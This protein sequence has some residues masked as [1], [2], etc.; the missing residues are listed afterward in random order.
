MAQGRP[1]LRSVHRESPGRVIEPRKQSR[2]EADTVVKVEG[3]RVR[4]VSPEASHSAG[5]KSRAWST[6]GFPRNLGGLWFSV[7]NQ[8]VRAP[9][10][11]WSRLA[12]QV[13]C[14]TERKQHQHNGTLSCKGHGR[15]QRSRSFLIG[16]DEAG[17]VSRAEPVEG[18][19]NRV[20]VLEEEQMA[21]TLN[22]QTISTQQL[23]LAKR[24]KCHSHDALLTLAHF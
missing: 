22:P 23:E 13:Q 16:T 21:G 19:G 12:A 6:C 15:K 11:K 1:W 7:V 18:R 8:T 20:K 17:D 9:C 4:V 14:R 24:A 5:S 10:N 2:S 3:S